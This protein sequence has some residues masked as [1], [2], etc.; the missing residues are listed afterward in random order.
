M[1]KTQ[2]N[3]WTLNYGCKKTKE[4]KT[5]LHTAAADA[6]Q[7]VKLSMVAVLCLP[8]KKKLKEFKRKNGKRKQ[9]K[10]AKIY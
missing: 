6:C 7:P 2:Y 4:K 10:K 1:S 8:W 5:Q 3:Y 9:K